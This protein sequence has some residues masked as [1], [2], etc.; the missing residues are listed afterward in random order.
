MKRLVSSSRLAAFALVV[1]LLIALCAGTLYKL[2]IIEGAAYYEESQNSLTSYPSVTA[3]RGNILDRYGR[4]LVSN[5]EC[6]N[7]KISDTRLFSDEVEDPN[8]VILQMINLVEA[9][10]ETYT[11]DLPITLEPPFEYTNM[12]DI[13]RTLLDAYL[14]A[15]GLDEDTTAVELMSYFRTRY[16]IAN[17]YTAEEMRKIASVRYAVNVRYEINTNSY[18][19]VEDASIDL[20]SDLMGVV[21]NVVEVETSYVREY[22]TQYAAHIL[23]YVQAM[24]EE[25]MAK[26]RPEDEN[27]GYDY[28]TKVGRDGVEA[29]FEDWLHGTNGEARVTRTANGTVTSTVYLEDPV[30]GNHVYLTI[31]IQLQE[32]AERILETGIYELQIERNDDN[33]EAVA[34]GRLDEVREDIQGG[35]IVVVDVKT[36]EPLAIASY[37]TYD[38][39]TIIED[40]ADLL[41]ADYDPLFNRALMGA[42][43]PGSTFKPCT[44]IA[45]LTENI[46]NTETQIE[47]TGIFTKYES[48]GYAPACWIY[49]QM[50]GQLTH[51]YDN[52]TEALKDSCNIFFYT[53]A[54]DLG[55]RKLMEYAED[56]G[57]GEST[58][59]ELTETTGNMSNP[60]NHLNYDVDGW[61]DGDTVQA[62]I[63]QSDSMF[64]PLQIAEYCAAIANGGTRHSAALLKSVRSYDYSRQLYQNK[65]EVLS[66]V[67]SADYNWAA[68]QRGMYLMANDITSSS[69]TVYYTLG[70]YSYNG[71]SL[72]VAAKTGTSQLGEG[73]TNNAIFMCYAPFDDPEIAVAIVV[74]RGLSGAN[75][76][77]MARN[78]LDAYFSLGS[79][80]NTAE[81]ENSLLK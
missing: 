25:D 30:P 74:E 32:Q 55:I 17:S 38:L 22:N 61:V 77:R 9:A 57:L 49:T 28:D 40:Y 7:L 51:G 71:V 41:E 44:A 68:V 79:I 24:S 48:Q 63:G 33:A 14:K 5:R 81:R 18:I 45:G 69:N 53:V 2:Q 13:Q 76:S 46:I 47:C 29:A 37:P 50:D 67:D 42:Y 6:Y 1:V 78:V 54:D 70:N 23:G 65:T 15:K 4:V 26:Y 60:D 52:V 75:L 10:G 35:A 16:E 80:S 39:A 43:A 58:G 12:T 27:S 31:D 21:G 59:I 72:P 62:G 36:G 56:F 64:T 8:A 73:K 19:F 66:T 20:I 11:D 3:A 34:E